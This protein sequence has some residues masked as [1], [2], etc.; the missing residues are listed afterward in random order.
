MRRQKWRKVKGSVFRNQA[1]SLIFL[2]RGDGGAPSKVYVLGPRATGPEPPESRS[3]AVVAP[4]FSRP[5][6]FA[7]RGVAGHRFSG[8]AS[9]R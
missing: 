8:R 3:A 2:G 5:A 6:A 7:P 9:F 4:E 1:L